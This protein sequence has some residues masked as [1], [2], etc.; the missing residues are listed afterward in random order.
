MRLKPE[1]PSHGMLSSMDQD[2]IMRP[3]AARMGRP[4]D[5]PAGSGPSEADSMVITAQSIAFTGRK[6]SHD[7]S[8]LV[9]KKK[10]K[11]NKKQ[12]QQKTT[13]RKVNFQCFCFNEEHDT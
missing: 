12:Q 6:L 4:R 10:K 2:A 8:K 3:R 11:P 9:Y 5:E 1:D 7:Q 13:Q